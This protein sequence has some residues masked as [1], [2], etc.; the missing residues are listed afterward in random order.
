MKI[1]KN[2]IKSIFC[3]FSLNL[4]AGIPAASGF[5]LGPTVPGKWGAPGI[6]N[7]SDHHV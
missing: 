3:I 5:V 6:R 7:W 4:L 1:S 2:G